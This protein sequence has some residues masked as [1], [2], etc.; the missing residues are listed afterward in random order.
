MKAYWKIKRPS[1][2]LTHK[3]RP[4]DKRLKSFLEE[5]LALELGQERLVYAAGSLQAFDLTGVIIEE[6]SSEEIKFFK[7]H[8]Y[9]GGLFG[10]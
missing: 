7:K 8:D 3:N 6:P 2:L 10:P 1:L 5:L 4:R 9:T